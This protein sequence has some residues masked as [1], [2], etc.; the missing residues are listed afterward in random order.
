MAIFGNGNVLCKMVKHVSCSK[1]KVSCQEQ[2]GASGAQPLKH[3]I[4]IITNM[5]HV[6]NNNNC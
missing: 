2:P 6:N 1:A 4:L 5:K 3:H